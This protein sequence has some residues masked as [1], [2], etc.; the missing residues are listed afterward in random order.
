MPSERKKPHVDGTGTDIMVGNGIE[1]YGDLAS[2]D[3]C[4]DAGNE[5]CRQLVSYAI[6]EACNTKSY[7]QSL[8]LSITHTN[9]SY[10]IFE[11]IF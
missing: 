11:I 8:L 9:E 10:L 5:Q 4:K 1:T 7:R 2:M 3:S 6:E